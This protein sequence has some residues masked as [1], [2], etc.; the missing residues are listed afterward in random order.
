MDKQID[1]RKAFEN[2]YGNHEPNH[3]EDDY[4]DRTN[5]DFLFSV[6]Q[7]AIAS[8]SVELEDKVKDPN[9]WKAEAQS[10]INNYLRLQKHVEEEE[11]RADRMT[12]LAH[13][14]D[15]ERQKQAQQ[16]AT[17]EQILRHIADAVLD[18][19]NARTSI[20]KAAEYGAGLFRQEP[21]KP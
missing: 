17:L 11:A 3:K 8:I 16:I 18:I 9:Q 14:Y 15:V 19:N 13:D 4:Y 21:E 5:R 10:Q 1:S 2:W 12:A 7:A 20:S 6:W